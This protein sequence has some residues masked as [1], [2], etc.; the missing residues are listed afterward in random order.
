MAVLGAT[1]QHVD[2][3]KAGVMGLALGLELLEVLENTAGE[4]AAEVA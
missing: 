2:K 4:G 1:L 3:D